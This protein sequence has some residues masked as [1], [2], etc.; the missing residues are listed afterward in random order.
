MTHARSVNGKQCWV[1]GGHLAAKV[2]YPSGG[3]SAAKVSYPCIRRALKGKVPNP[4]GGH[5][6]VGFLPISLSLKGKSSL[7]FVYTTDGHSAVK[8]P[9]LTSTEHSALI[10]AY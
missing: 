5:S 2:P 1:A 10:V 4:T 8:V 3:H 7:Q 6:S 9:Y